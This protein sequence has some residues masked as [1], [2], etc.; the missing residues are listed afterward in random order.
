MSKKQQ[1]LFGVLLILTAVG[2]VVSMTLDPRPKLLKLYDF[3]VVI[4]WGIL[5]FGVWNKQQNE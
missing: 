3:L 2:F 1:I 5:I 4:G